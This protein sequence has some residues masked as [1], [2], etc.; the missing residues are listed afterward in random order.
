MNV[1]HAVCPR[2]APCLAPKVLFRFSANALLLAAALGTP[3]LHAQTPSTPDTPKTASVSSADDPLALAKRVGAAIDPDEEAVTADAG[4]AG[5]VPLT[6]GFNASLGT[7]SQHDSA[8]GWSSLLT[9]NLAYRF[10]RHFSLNLGLPVFTY[11]NVAKSKA[12]AGSL[13]LTT[14]SLVPE[15]LLLGDTTLEGGFD[16]HAAWLDYNL[17]ATLGMPSGDN[18]DGIGAGQIT[19]AFI[20]HFEHPLGDFLVPNLELGIDDSPNLVDTRVRKSYTDI[21]TNAHFQ[22]GIGLSLPYNIYFESDAYEELPLSTQTITSTTTNGKKGKQQKIIT[23]TSQK[24]IGEDNGFQNSL[25]VPLTSHITLSGF[26]NRSLRD[27]IDTAGFSLTF[28]LRAP[29]RAGATLIR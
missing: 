6:K 25:D 3:M 15:H 20:N 10:N 5:I 23:T 27:K 13:V 22:A 8:G 14:T 19:Y 1:L 29:P 12:V 21:G 26:Y 4:P 2:C 28:L 7:T 24:S 17:T 18:A 16:A 11:I 9:P